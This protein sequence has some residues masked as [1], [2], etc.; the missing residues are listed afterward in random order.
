MWAVA[1]QRQLGMTFAPQRKSDHILCM[2]PAV[3]AFIQALFTE[4]CSALGGAGFK[5]VAGS[6]L[7]SFL[8]KDLQ[9]KGHWEISIRVEDVGLRVYACRCTNVLIP[10]TTVR[11]ET[12]KVLLP[13]LDRA[14][15]SD[16][17]ETKRQCIHWHLFQPDTVVLLAANICYNIAC[18]RHSVGPSV[19]SS[20]CH[21]SLHHELLRQLGLSCLKEELPQHI[22][23][24]L[25]IAARVRIV[26]SLVWNNVSRGSFGI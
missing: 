24:H 23:I 6:F 11:G 15:M 12:K 1:S 14:V 22:I 18:C 7:G 16:R 26:H 13:P 17:K 9:I 10:K 4:P 20:L 2:S 8:C 25:H 21:S 5:G 19:L 3:R